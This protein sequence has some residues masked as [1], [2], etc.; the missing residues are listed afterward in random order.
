[1][2]EMKLATVDH[3]IVRVLDYRLIGRAYA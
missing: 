3:T 1:M 2:T